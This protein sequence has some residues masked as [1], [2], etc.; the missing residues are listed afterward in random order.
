MIS[1]SMLLSVYFIIDGPKHGMRLTV[2]LLRPHQIWFVQSGGK[3]EIWFAW[4]HNILVQMVKTGSAAG[5]ESL[6]KVWN[7]F[8]QFPDLEKVWKFV[9]SFGNFKKRFETFSLLP[10][11]KFWRPK[12]CLPLERSEAAASRLTESSSRVVPSFHICSFSSYKLRRAGPELLARRF[13]QKMHAQNSSFVKKRSFASQA[14]DPEFWLTVFVNA[15]SSPEPVVCSLLLT[16]PAS[17]TEPLPRKCDCFLPARIFVV[18]L[19]LPQ[20]HDKL[21][22]PLLCFLFF[23]FSLKKASARFSKCASR[24]PG[25]RCGRTRPDCMFV[26]DRCVSDHVQSTSAE[27]SIDLAGASR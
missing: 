2:L 15:E 1:L 17:R 18:S 27:L 11:R 9:K 13:K 16:L 22:F 6:E 21:S 10:E 24:D 5:M 23:F 26:R 7:L 25:T 8:F 19:R 14:V 12:V 3:S 4:N 20:R